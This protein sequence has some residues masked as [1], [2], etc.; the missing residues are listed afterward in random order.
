MARSLQLVD[1]FTDTVGAGNRAG[2]VLDAD[3]LAAADMQR[4]AASVDASETAFGFRSGDPE[5][6][7]LQVRYFSPTREIPLCG[8]A[9]IGF[10]HVRS[11]ALGLA[12]QT[13]RVKTGAGILPIQIVREDGLCQVVMTQRTPQVLRTLSAQERAQVHGALGL[14]DSAAVSDW[15][16]QVVCTGHAKVLLPVRTWPAL[17]ALMPDRER[18]ITLSELLGA[19]GYFAFTLDRQRQDILYHGRM[20]APASGVDEDPVTGNANGPAGFYLLQH[21]RLKMPADGTCRYRAA[22]G[23]TMG[24]PG[25]IEVILSADG[26]RG[27]RVQVTGSAVVA[28][29]V[30]V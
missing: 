23:E 17:A 9:T 14:V 28:S 15:P 3:G 1:V 6:Y 20:F 24:R 26:A 4:I 11:L 18:L 5:Q 8:H 10:H 19:A 25:V 30:S 27:V 12:T 13:L 22:Q 29:Q 7:D 2:V 16:S 21:G